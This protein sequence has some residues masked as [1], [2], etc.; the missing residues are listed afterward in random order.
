MKNES[1]ELYG[2]INNTFNNDAMI[3]DFKKE[4][5]EKR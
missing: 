3:Q 5:E 4:L 2:F 1:L